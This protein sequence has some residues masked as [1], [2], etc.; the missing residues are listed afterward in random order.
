MSL[1]AN[2]EAIEANIATL[3]LPDGQ[4]LKIA[5]AD[6]H[7]TPKI[8]TEIHVLVSVG[9]ADQSNTQDLARTLLNELIS[10]EKQ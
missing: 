8:G 10:T 7:G 2:I 4:I 9:T 6:I 1:K 3:R 5:L